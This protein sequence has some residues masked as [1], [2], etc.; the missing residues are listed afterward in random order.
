MSSFLFTAAMLEP[1]AASLEQRLAQTL[2]GPKP[3]AILRELTNPDGSMA[4]GD[5]IGQ[6]AGKPK[7]LVLSIAPLAQ[8]RP[9]S[10]D[11]SAVIEN[12]KSS[13]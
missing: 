4:K 9:R 6:F 8:Q 1:A 2:A 7:I 12:A 3:A 11:R 13:N 10:T 5:C